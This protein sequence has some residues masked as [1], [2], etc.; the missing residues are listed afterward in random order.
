[1]STKKSATKVSKPST[2]TLA[3]KEE[4]PV[5]HDAS[6]P[7]KKPLTLNQL[8]Q[9]LV[10]AKKQ[11]QEHTS[12]ISQLQD[13]LSH[14][15][16]PVASNGKVQIRDKQTGKVYP[17]KNSVYQTMLKA[18]ELKELVDKLGRKGK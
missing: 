11:L 18:G 15:R 16:R 4:P 2:I 3:P 1:M 9:E 12:L 7:E 6:K 5:P 8:N 10:L 17:S 14:K 13:T